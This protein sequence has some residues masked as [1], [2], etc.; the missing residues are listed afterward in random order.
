MVSSCRST[1]AHSFVT[2]INNILTCLRLHVPNDIKNFIL[3][4]RNQ[5]WIILS[6]LAFHKTPK[7]IIQACEI[8]H[9]ILE[10]N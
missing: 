7:K 6:N 10:T 4:F 1:D 3:K 8:N 5:L 2:I 9:M